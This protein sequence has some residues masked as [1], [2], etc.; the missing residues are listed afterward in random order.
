MMNLTPSDLKIEVYPAPMRTG[1]Q[2]GKMAPGVK[3]T[4]MPSGLWVVCDEHRHQYK[5]RK[6]ALKELQSL[7]SSKPA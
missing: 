7:V 6:K 4:H 3:I 2:T 5:N 1:M